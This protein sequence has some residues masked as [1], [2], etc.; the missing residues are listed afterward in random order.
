MELCEAP[1][2]VEHN[3]Q[4]ELVDIYDEYT[5]K[6]ILKFIKKYDFPLFTKNFKKNNNSFPYIKKGKAKYSVLMTG[7]EPLGIVAYVEPEYLSNYR[8]IHGDMDYKDYSHI[9][10]IEVRNS[11]RGKG[12]AS[13]LIKHVESR[14]KSE[15]TSKGITL[16][17]IDEPTIDFYKELGFNTYD[18]TKMVKRF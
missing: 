2:R 8:S 3:P 7:K 15:T 14:L 13:S 5:T 18:N 12:Y 4:G 11:Y 1:S 10:D 16:M 17:S 6:D 9:F